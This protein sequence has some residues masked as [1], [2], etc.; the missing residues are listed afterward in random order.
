MNQKTILTPMKNRNLLIRTL[1]GLV[2]VLI[3]IGGIVYGPQTFTTLF[4][5]I[6]ALSVWEFCTILNNHADLR[7]NR[8][9]TTIAAIYLFFAVFSFNLSVVDSTIF[10]PYLLL[11]L[12]LMISELYKAHPKDIYNL[13]FSMLAQLYV[14]L[15]FALMNV[16]AFIL[17]P[18]NA[19]G[20][21]PS[22]RIAYT[23][24]FTL[25]IFIFLW[26][27]DTGAYCAGSLFGKHRLFPRISPKKSWEGCI[28]GAVLALFASQIIAF[29][30][31]DFSATNEL[32]NRVVWAGLALFVV[33]F[34]TWGDLVESMLKRRLGIKDSGNIMPGHGGMLDRFDS[35]L[36]AIPAAVIY[37]Y[38]I[39]LF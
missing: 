11:L 19:Q 29:F 27:N 20:I 16:L 6:T 5:V 35:A 30:S 12:Y 17:V 3:L 4:A 31:H 32:L 9:I 23:W 10:L 33:V 2:F 1:T 24:I 7:I 25:S 8:F 38:T 28:G 14:A 37:L 34:G 18:D 15:P 13:A 21:Y 39:S 36:L 22:H 26:T